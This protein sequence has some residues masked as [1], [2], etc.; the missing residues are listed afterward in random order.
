MLGVIVNVIT[1]IIGGG[2]GLLLKKG[3]PERI[4][5][6]LM[7]GIGLCT[8]YIGISSALGGKN[9]L[10][11]IISMALGALIGQLLCLEERFSAVSERLEKKFSGNGKTSLAQGFITASLVFCVGSM[12]IVGSIQAGMGD[13][14]M[15]FAKSALDFCSSLVF[16]SSLGFGVVLSSL[17]VLVF[18]GAIA[19]LSSVVAP[20]LSEVVIAEMTCAGGVLIL[21]LGLN[22]LGITKLKVMNYLPA[23]FIPIILC[24]IIK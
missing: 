5:D 11:L 10:I 2:I 16:A 21:G 18:Q 17:F 9:P 14:D 7:K 6:T 1:V 13:N 23:I 22:I 12:T 24:M 3:I 19:L 8:L 4:T 20:L 15:L